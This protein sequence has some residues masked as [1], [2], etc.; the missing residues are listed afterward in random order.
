MI[1]SPV[2]PMVGRLRGDDQSAS[3]RLGLTAALSYRIISRFVTPDTTM[4]AS[5]PRR[6][7][8]D[9]AATSFP[10]PRAVTDAMV[11]YANGKWDGEEMGRGRS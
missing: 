4:N 3:H 2:E 11:R 8:M 6:L 9:N 7:Y 10:K 5:A 1:G